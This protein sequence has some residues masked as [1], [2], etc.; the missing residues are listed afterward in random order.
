MSEP[1]SQCNSMHNFYPTI[2]KKKSLC[3][4]MSNIDRFRKNRN[5]NTS[6]LMEQA[7]NNISKSMSFASKN[8]QQGR[9]LHKHQTVLSMLQ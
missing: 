6:S 1:V 3:T 5:L 4:K 9:N 2:S 7:S 8:R